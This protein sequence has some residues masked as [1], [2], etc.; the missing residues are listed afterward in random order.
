M[1]IGSRCH[2]FLSKWP[3]LL[4]TLAGALVA[5]TAFELALRPF[6]GTFPHPGFDEV[7]QY[8]EGTSVARYARPADPQPLT[9]R[10]TGNEWVDGAPTIVII[11]DSYMA[12]RHVPDQATIGSLIERWSRAEGLPL[13]IRQYGIPSGAPP[14]FAGFADRL[15]ARWSPEQVVVVITSNDLGSDPLLKSMYWRMRIGTDGSAE[16]VEAPRQTPSR[17]TPGVFWTP[18]VS[19]WQRSSLAE[20]LWVRWSH[21]NSALGLAARPKDP[22]KPPDSQVASVPQASVTLLKR[23]YGAR[24]LIVFLAEIGMDSDREPSGEELA[25]ERACRAAGIPYA[26]SRLVF[27]AMRDQSVYSRGFHNTLPGAG[28][29]NEAGQHAFAGVVWQL[30]KQVRD[31]TG[32]AATRLPI[33]GR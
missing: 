9:W 19:L 5:L 32:L 22:P 24:L 7:R 12:A 26:S 6:T 11:G 21:L 20:V 31:G 14:T 13:N 33:R 10:I 3:R 15:L 25:L 4:T 23:A 28:H 27:I 29:L 1:I 18:F 17:P 8:A 16:L 30:L 2:R